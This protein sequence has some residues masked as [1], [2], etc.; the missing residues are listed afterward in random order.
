[1]NEQLGKFY[2]TYTYAGWYPMIDLSFDYG[3]R[4]DYAFLPELTEIKWNETNL[5]AGLRLPL[6]FTKS[7]YFS[8]LFSYAYANQIIRRIQSPDSIDFRKPDIFSSWYGLRYYRQIKTSLRDIY[9]RWG[10]SLGIYYRHTPLEASNNSEIAAVILNL[11]FPGILRHHAI[12]VYAAYQE[13]EIG[14]YKFSDLAAYPRGYTGLQHEELLSLRTTYA[15]PVV[16]P[17]WS[18]GPVLYLKRIRANLFYDYAIGR[19]DAKNYYNSLGADLL[20]E[21]HLL[22]FFAPIEMGVRAV[23]L[24]RNAKLEWEFLISVGFDSF[25][26]GNENRQAVIR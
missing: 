10:Q 21:T 26:V 22:R 13:R 16:Y 9:P 15:F 5:R 12:N 1:V 25:Y 2:G 7:K 19:N 8:G 4:R 6:N 20:A 11:Y 17:D 3:L 18:L 24:P 14:Y 23:Y